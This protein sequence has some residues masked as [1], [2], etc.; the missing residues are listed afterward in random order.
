MTF[1]AIEKGFMDPQTI[2]ISQN[3]D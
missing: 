1:S 2:E 3:L